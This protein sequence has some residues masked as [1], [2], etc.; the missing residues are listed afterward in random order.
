MYGVH[1]CSHNNFF[2]SFFSEILFCS[3]GIVPFVTATVVGVLAFVGTILTTAFIDK[4]TYQRSNEGLY[5]PYCMY[6]F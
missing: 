6:K 4:V 2:V 1:V 3:L 5:L